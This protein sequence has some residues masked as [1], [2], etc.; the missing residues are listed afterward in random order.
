MTAKY[1]PFFKLIVLYH[2]SVKGLFLV[3]G[4]NVA[5][6]E[7]APQKVIDLANGE[8]AKVGTDP[9]IVNAVKAE[10]GKGKTLDQIKEKDKKWKATAGIA[11]YMKALMDSRSVAKI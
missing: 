3:A 4:F 10:N 6:A 9:V 7:K 2:L 1:C 5:Y 11:D 8:L